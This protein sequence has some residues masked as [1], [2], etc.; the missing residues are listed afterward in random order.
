[1]SSFRSY[2]SKMRKNNKL[3]DIYD[4]LNIDNEISSAI[5]KASM[6]DHG[7]AAYCHKIDGYPEWSV[8][9]GMY[10]TDHLLAYSIGLPDDNL[11][12]YYLTIGS[13]NIQP[14]LVSS[15]DAKE[16]ILKDRDI[17]LY[18][19][20]FLVHCEDDESQYHQSG[21]I[22]TRD[23]DNNVNKGTV[24]R[25]ELLSKN[26]M[27]IYSSQDS[28]L[29]QLFKKNRLIG[30]DTEVA[31]VIG[32][33]PLLYIATQFPN[34][35]NI[36]CIELAG[37]MKEKP[38]D[39][40][41]CETLDLYVPSEAEVIIEGMVTKDEVYEGKWGTERGNYVLLD[42][43]YTRSE[44]D[45]DDPKLVGYKFEVTAITRR[46]NPIYLDMMT[47][48][49]NAEDRTLCRYIT[50]M[51]IY[52]ICVSHLHSKH[53]FV[54]VSV[55]QSA[56]AVI[57]IRNAGAGVAKKI[58]ND[59]M[60]LPLLTSIVVVDDDIDVHSH[61]AVS[62]ALVTRTTASKDIIIYPAMS[63]FETMDKFGIDATKPKYGPIKSQKDV[64]KRSVPRYIDRIVV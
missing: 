11:L 16:I 2:L 50:I 5:Y 44:F 21:I 57:S 45:T 23:R 56:Y 18:K 63:G 20:P 41:E 39:I 52:K 7:Y 42:P 33:D 15:S 9:G 62:W 60:R 13:K 12:S 35:L 14:A 30:K 47:G 51:E 48:F 27:A 4:T 34:K 6:K 10:S 64:F 61:D 37:G 31:V 26:S 22:F 1:M 8:V 53:D 25:I 36:G 46:S 29:F 3:I 38:I 55:K 28:N 32:A 49:G 43:Q 58:I 59:A 40:I 19:I 17:D 24:K 54:D